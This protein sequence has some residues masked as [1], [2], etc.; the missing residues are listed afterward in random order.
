MNDRIVSKV[1]TGMGV[2]SAV[3]EGQ[4]IPWLFVFDW[5]F[6]EFESEKRVYQFFVATV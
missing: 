1:Q 6:S 4:N 3:F 2:R 5:T